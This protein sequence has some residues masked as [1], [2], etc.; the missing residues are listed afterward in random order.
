MKD[1]PSTSQP[2]PT[3]PMRRSLCQRTSESAAKEE[4]SL[5]L[6]VLDRTPVKMH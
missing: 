4:G 3:T 5:F 1:G 2:Q 6:G